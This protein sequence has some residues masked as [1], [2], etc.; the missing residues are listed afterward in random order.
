[1]PGKGL[2]VERF[3]SLKVLNTNKASARLKAITPT[4]LSKSK[5]YSCG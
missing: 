2:K 1:M 4:L 3:R 5:P